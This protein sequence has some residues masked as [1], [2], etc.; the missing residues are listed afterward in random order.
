MN[1]TTWTEAD[2]VNPRAGSEAVVAGTEWSG[3]R[4]FAGIAFWPWSEEE[5]PETTWTES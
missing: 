1:A 2:V 3:K 4:W 5:K